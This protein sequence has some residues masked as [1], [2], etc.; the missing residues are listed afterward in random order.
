MTQLRVD[1]DEKSPRKAKI[2]E[3]NFQWIFYLFGV[4][5]ASHGRAVLN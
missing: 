1:R 2:A 4:S 3:F 5:Y